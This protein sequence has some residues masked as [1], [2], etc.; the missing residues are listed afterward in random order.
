MV[1]VF[2]GGEPRDSEFAA[3]DAQ[4]RNVH[5]F[6]FRPAIAR[7]PGAHFRH[8]RFIA[9]GSP[10]VVS[11]DAARRLL[12]SVD[13]R[14]RRAAHRSDAFELQHADLQ[15]SVGRRRR[16]FRQRSALLTGSDCQSVRLQHDVLAVRK[17]SPSLLALADEVIENGAI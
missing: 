2:F 8:R 14:A 17:F 7:I 11:G 1:A 6:R 16:S 12:W 4:P 15:S 9:M 3:V 5:G 13:C 10:A